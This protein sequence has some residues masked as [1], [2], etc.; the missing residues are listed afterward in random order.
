V[1]D[2]ARQRLETKTATADGADEAAAAVTADGAKSVGGPAGGAHYCSG[3]Q[4]L[5]ILEDTLRWGN[6][7]PTCPGTVGV[8]HC[9]CCFALFSYS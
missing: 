1:A 8:L 3:E 7:C 5:N 4:S 2:I 6:I 9:V